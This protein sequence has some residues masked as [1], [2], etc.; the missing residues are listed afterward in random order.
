MIAVTVFGQN[1][2]SIWFKNRHRDH[3]PFTVIGNIVISVYSGTGDVVLIIPIEQRE[4][5]LP[6]RERKKSRGNRFTETSSRVR[7]CWECA[8]RF[9]I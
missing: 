5:R 3:I 6:G 7:R 8:R 1:G 9:N 4:T 2:I